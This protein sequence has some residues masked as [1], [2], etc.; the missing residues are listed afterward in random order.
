[1]SCLVLSCSCLVL[2]C[3]VLSCLA[4]SCLV[5]SCLAWIE[6]LV[7]SSYFVF[8]ARLGQKILSCLR[9][10]SLWLVGQNISTVFVLCCLVL[11][12]LLFSCLALPCLVFFRKTSS[13]FRFSFRKASS[14]IIIITSTPCLLGDVLSPMT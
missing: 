11:S 14:S 1:M 8:V 2:S 5:L 12:C 13:P 7:L 6:N 10:L 4:L 9:V 3:L